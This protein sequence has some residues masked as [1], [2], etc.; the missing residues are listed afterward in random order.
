MQYVTQTILYM[1]NNAELVQLLDEFADILEIMD[2][3]TFRIRAYRNGARAVESCGQSLEDIVLDDPSALKNIDGIGKGLQEKIIEYFRTGRIEEHDELLQEIPHGLIDML[4]IQSF[5]PKRVKLVYNALGI[6]SV[7]QLEEAAENGALRSLPGLGEKS[8]KKLLRAIRNFRTLRTDRIAWAEAT[9]IVEPYIAYL[10]KNTTATSILPAGSYR[11][12][13]ETVGDIDILTTTEESGRDIVETFVKYKDVDEILA[14]GDTKGSVILKRKIQVDLRVV[15]PDCYGAALQYFTG[16]KEHNVALRT[17]AKDKGLKVSEYGVFEGKEKLAGK[18]EEDVYAALDCQWI[19][20]ELRENR[21]EIT[22]AVEDTLPQLV[23]LD[24][25]KGDMHMHTDYTDGHA[26]IRGMINAAR[27][28]GYEYIAV[29]DHSKA[30][31]VANGLDD[32]RVKDQLKE[33]NAIRK[34]FDDIHVFSGIE[35]DIKS[36]GSLD[37]ADDTLELLDFVIASVHFS[38]EMEKDT[39]T[40]RIIKAIQHPC[41]N[42]I[43]HPT[44]RLVGERMPYEVNMDAIIEAAAENRVALEIN[45]SPHRLDLNEY[46]ADMARKA[47]VPLCINTDSHYTDSLDTIRFGIPIARRAWCEKDDILNAW[48]VKKLHDWCAQ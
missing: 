43:G 17:R 38:L 32:A 45:S 2:A 27:E 1:P 24:D 8:E 15:E 13:R 44:G 14:Q 28:R 21:G 41:V 42:C 46:H 35:V 3:N 37:L 25:I 11:R 33:L 48:P 30:V 34:D 36:D 20:P 9:E 7:D 5:G 16:S 29:T 4:K 6:S 18:T 23:T 26:D 12:C 31:A 10:R 40:S 39:M 22:A 19:P 47:G